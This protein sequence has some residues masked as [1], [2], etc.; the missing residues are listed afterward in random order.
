MFRTR[1]R[2][3]T[4]SSRPI[5]KC[6]CFPL[7]NANN[8]LYSFRSECFTNNVWNRRVDLASHE[9]VI[10]YAADSVYHYIS[11][12]TNQDG[13]GAM[14]ETH[15][16]PRYAYRGVWLTNAQ[17][18]RDEAAPVEHVVFMV[19]GIGDFCDISFRKLVD[20]VDDF[21]EISADLMGSH[22]GH[23]QEMGRV[24]VLP[25]SWHSALHTDQLDAHL[26]MITL[27]SI[28][29]IRA[30][31]NDTIMDALFY[32]APQHS[33]TIRHAVASELNRIYTLFLSRNPHFTGTIALGGHSLGSLILFDLLSHQASHQEDPHLASHPVEQLYFRPAAFF[34]FGS[35]IPVFL[36]VR[37]IHQLDGNFQLPTCPS[38]Y[39]IFHPY[40]PIAYRIEPLIDPDSA[41]LKPVLVPHHKGRKRFHLEIKDSITRMGT[42]LKEKVL[43]SIKGTLDSVYGFLKAHQR[44]ASEGDGSAEGQQLLTEGSEEQQQQSSTTTQEQT[45]FST[46]PSC[47]D[48]LS[49]T[50]N[51]NDLSEEEQA[52]VATIY[53]G[54]LNSGR[55]IDYVLQ[56]RPIEIVNEYL[57]AIAAHGCYW[58][59][60][61]TALLVLRELYGKKG[62]VP[63]FQEPQPQTAS[64]SSATDGG[65]SNQ[66]ARMTPPGPPPPK[67]KYSELIQ[68]TTLASTSPTHSNANSSPTYA[69]SPSAPLSPPSFTTPD[70]FS[71]PSTHQQQQL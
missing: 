63:C 57:F 23:E 46:S 9:F 34:A 53:F 43:T 32:T 19:H 6:A 18:E 39:N 42:E 5:G 36:S 64:Q 41:K 30:F 11:E 24:E 40:D 55:R 22:Y 33:Q 17:K 12:T 1:K 29:R 4:F 15:M 56:E 25:I 38:F 68:Q 65:G 59:S 49:V 47:N 8:N 20:V 31:T 48:I 61:D 44:T 2:W 70:S 21:R 37:G 7:F 13:W 3:Q 60:E 58:L 54:R 26:K 71:P 66:T 16:T 69:H 52:L 10:F 35:P 51:N 28:P 27:P 62:C 14:M 67:Q 45:T 50:N